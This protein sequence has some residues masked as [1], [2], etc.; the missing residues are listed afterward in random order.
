M[1]R[2]SIILLSLGLLISPFESYGQGYQKEKKVELA[3]P[4]KPVSFDKT[5]HNFGLIEKGNPATATF[6][7]KN[8]GT[9]PL[10]I[11]SVKSSCGCTVP[12]Y[13]KQP[14]QSGKT[15]EIKLTYNSKISGY[16]KKSAQVKTKDGKIHVLY[17]EGTVK[18]KPSKVGK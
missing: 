15:G 4:I 7:I 9:E 11:I 12:S 14:L 13:P 8:N 5:T 10:V 3:K 1:I 16:F 6:T 2:L 18:A 17:I